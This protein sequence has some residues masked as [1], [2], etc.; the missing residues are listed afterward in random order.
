M[1]LWGATKAVLSIGTAVI[2]LLTT[3]KSS[4]PLTEII[5]MIGSLL[6]G[7]PNP[8]PNV[9]VGQILAV[10]LSILIVLLLLYFLHKFITKAMEEFKPGETWIRHNKQ[11]Y[12]MSMEIMNYLEG[13]GDYEALDDD[14]AYA[15]FRKNI[16]T[17]WL[18]NLQTF[19]TA[20]D[21]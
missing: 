16:E 19:W 2:F 5:A 10:I 8:M 11:C 6:T 15:D 12:K 1:G 9:S 18:D 14:E 7:V 4:V 20:M 17:M 21:K 3:I 13:T